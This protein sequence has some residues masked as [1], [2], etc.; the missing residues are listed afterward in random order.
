MIAIHIG[1][2]TPILNGAIGGCRVV[3]SAFFV[4]FLASSAIA[5]DSVYGP[6]APLESTADSVRSFTPPPAIPEQLGESANRAVRSYPAIQ[7]AEA[8]ILATDADVRAAKWLRF[9]SVSV[10]ARIDD[11]NLG[12]ISPQISVQQPLWAGG[13]I[14]ASINRAEAGRLV[15]DARLAETIQ[16]LSFQ[17]L[18]AY[19][20]V[21]RAVKRESIL[22]DSLAEHERLVESMA[23]RVEQEVSPRSDLEL[24]T[25]RAAQVEQQLSLTTA[26]R[27]TNLQRLAELTGEPDFELA[28]VP[29]YSPAVHHPSTDAA[30]AQALA[31]DPTRRRL[32]AESAIAEAEKDIAQSSIF[33][34]VGLELSNDDVYG[35]RFGLVVSAQT[36]GG[37]SPFAAA[38]V[39]PVRAPA[40]SAAPTPRPAVPAASPSSRTAPA[41]APARTA[42]AAPAS[43]T[44]L[45]PART[46]TASTASMGVDRP[47]APAGPPLGSPARPSSGA[48]TGTRPAVGAAPATAIAKPVTVAA[49]PAPAAPPGKVADEDLSVAEAFASFGQLPAPKAGPA[50]GAVDITAIE[51]RREPKP[52]P[53]PPPRP[54]PAAAPAKPAPPPPPPATKAPSRVWV[55]VATGKD[56]SALK[57]DWRRISRKAEGAL[58]AKGPFVAKWGEANRLLAGPYPSAAAARDAVRKLKDLGLDAFAFTSAAGEAVDPLK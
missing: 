58:N 57:F 20:E 44:R 7:A 54:A 55:Q 30:V 51:V 29:V 9:P 2:L 19:Y 5:Q 11:D 40:T 23:R 41:A 8:T 35:T 38:N 56:R 32:S 6:P 46:T 1:K 26:L 17:T 22:Q 3:G 28:A 14:T 49:A 25:S 52:A 4:T 33:P 34:R 18:N 48:S 47:L 53:P 24:A 31:C 43:T 39:A 36:N 37:L 42:A 16:D 45:P 12:G 50:N 21:V 13:S 15:A 10:G 27:Y